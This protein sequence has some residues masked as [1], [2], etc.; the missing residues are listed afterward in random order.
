MLNIAVRAA[1]RAGDI[2]ARSADQVDQLTIENK[3]D[4]D[5]VS[6][7]DRK[8]EEEI[9]Y[10]IRKAYPDHAILAEESGQ[11]AGNEYEWI[12]DPLDGTTNFVH[13]IPQFAV[14]IALRHKGRLDQAVVYDPMSQELFTASRGAGA[15]LNGKRIRVTSRKGLKGALLGTGIP[16]RDELPYLDAYLDMM[17]L[18]FQVPLEYAVPVRQHWTWPML[19]QVAWMVSGKS[20]STSG[21]WQP[22]FCLSKKPVASSAT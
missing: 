18:C 10:I 8:A 20:A 22:E 17:K 21:I 4:N 15:H 13:G 19:P 5:Y 7:V 14:S 6:E 12:I 16:F 11:H 2:I 9:I 1:R 3:A